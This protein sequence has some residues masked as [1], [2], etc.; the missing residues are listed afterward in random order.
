MH[1]RLTELLRYQVEQ[2]RLVLLTRSDPALPLHRLRLND[3]LGE[4]RARDLAFGAA[5]AT[6]AVR[7]RKAST[8]TWRT[9]RCWSSAPRAGP[10]GFGWP[11]CT[12]V[13]RAARRAASFAG[14]DQSVTGYLA[15]EVLASQP[16]ERSASSC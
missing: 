2:L 8:S 10:P 12:S 14:D 3:Q 4:L 13:A 9:R 15:E 11:R 16:P 6:Y 5:D 1:Q 7:G